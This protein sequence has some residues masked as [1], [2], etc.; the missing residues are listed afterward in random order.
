MVDKESDIR[1]IGYGAMLCEGFVGV[2]ALIA[3]SSLHP[4]DYFAINTSAG[5]VRARWASRR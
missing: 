5:D 2:M 1:P 3:A 4:G